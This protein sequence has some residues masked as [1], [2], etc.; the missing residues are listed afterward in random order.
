[1]FE[2]FENDISTKDVAITLKKLVPLFDIINDKIKGMGELVEPVKK[3]TGSVKWIK[4][5]CKIYMRV[6]KKSVR[7]ILKKNPVN[8]EM[9]T[10]VPVGNGQIKKVMDGQNVNDV[11]EI[12][13]HQDVPEQIE[14]H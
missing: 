13:C 5:Q 11:N 6:S 14:Y 3:V 1:M 8:A 7:Q 4:Y 2:E 9:P 12:E 10:I